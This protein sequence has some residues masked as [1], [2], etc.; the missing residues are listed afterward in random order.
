MIRPGIKNV[1]SAK[2]VARIMLSLNTRQ[3]VCFRALVASPSS[4]SSFATFFM[5]Q[6]LETRTDAPI[7]RPMQSIWKTLIK[8]LA[9][10]V[11]ESELSPR[12]PTIIVSSMFTPMVIRLC[13]AIG[14]A[15]L[16]TFI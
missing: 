6:Y 10:E 11:A 4:F 13:K 7:P 16:K 15:N 8:E 2:S 5:P 9:S 1:A 14:S 12:L 3:T